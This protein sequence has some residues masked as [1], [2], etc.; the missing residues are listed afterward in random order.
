LQEEA[1]AKLTAIILG[2]PAV[3]PVL[4]SAVFGM[5]AAGGHPV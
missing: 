2:P 4:P 1:G 3:A 5:S